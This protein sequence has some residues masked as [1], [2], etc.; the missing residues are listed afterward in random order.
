MEWEQYVHFMG[1][2]GVD[3]KADLF[4]K[5][6]KSMNLKVYFLFSL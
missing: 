1:R 3:F 2:Q 6:T 4:E 5:Q